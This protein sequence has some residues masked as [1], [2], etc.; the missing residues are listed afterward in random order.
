MQHKRT[1][2]T[3]PIPFFS[4]KAIC[5]ISCLGTGQGYLNT[6]QIEAAVHAASDIINHYSVRGPQQPCI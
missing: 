1:K 4:R 2:Q 6:I 3:K 5:Y